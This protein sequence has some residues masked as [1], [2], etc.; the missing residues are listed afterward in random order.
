MI[1][2]PVVL[3]Y[4]LFAYRVFRGKYPN[5]DGNHDRTRSALI[6]V[7]PSIRGKAHRISA[8]HRPG[9]LAAWLA[10]PSLNS[11]Q[12]YEG[13]H[14]FAGYCFRIYQRVQTSLLHPQSGTARPDNGRVAL[15]FTE[16]R[17]EICLSSDNVVVGLDL[18]VSDESTARFN[19]TFDLVKTLKAKSR[20]GVPSL[21]CW[22][23]L[24]K[25]I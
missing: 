20:A 16:S 19:D 12:D 25:P 4:S 6:L 17:V 10:G 23:R 1:V 21:S 11:A 3:A 14:H 24:K 18:F 22:R 8:L 5:K 13:I 7:W 9:P 15:R 2:T